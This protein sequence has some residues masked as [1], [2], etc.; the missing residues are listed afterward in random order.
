M[1]DTRSPA[2]AVITALMT[3]LA[4][5]THRTPT[6]RLDAVSGSCAVA[7]IARPY[8]V[9]ARNCSYPTMTANAAPMTSKTCQPTV[10]PRTWIEPPTYGSGGRTALEET[11]SY[12]L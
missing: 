9:R 10:A 3:K 11:F 6:P 8:A 7:L 5:M 4:R 1:G 2:I 12:T